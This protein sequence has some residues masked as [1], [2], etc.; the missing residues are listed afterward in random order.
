MSKQIGAI[1]MRQI[2]HSIS[3]QIPG[4]GF[5]LIVFE[6][7]E[8]GMGNYISN[9]QRDSMIKAFEE[10]LHRWKNNEDFETPVEN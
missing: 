7:H 9:A 2:A 1:K 8:P 3:K 6:F 4:L 5:A 10:V